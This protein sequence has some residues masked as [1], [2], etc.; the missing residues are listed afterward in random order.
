MIVDPPIL[1]I[2]AKFPRPARKIVEAFT[3]VPTG[4]A[5]DAM[6]GS[7]AID[8]RI[9]PLKVSEK[10]M[11]GVALTCS[12]GP[13]DNLA[14]F[15]ALSVAKPGDVLVAATGGYSGTAVTGDLLL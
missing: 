7:G 2:R 8:Y 4:H 12:A 1:S 3:G 13:A 10:V 14:I 11:V 5:V 15:G 6:G 9:K